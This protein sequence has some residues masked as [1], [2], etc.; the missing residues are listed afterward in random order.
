[1]SAI[2]YLN[3]DETEK[4]LDPWANHWVKTTVSDFMRKMSDMNQDI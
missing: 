1:M 3:A 2:L 4:D